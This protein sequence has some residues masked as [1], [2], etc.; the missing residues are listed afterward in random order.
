MLSFLTANLPTKMLDFRGFDYARLES[1]LALR[2][3][4]ACG[5][6]VARP[7]LKMP[8]GCR[9]ALRFACLGDLRANCTHLV[10]LLAVAR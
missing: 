7:C 1:G 9:H 3:R 4:T 8:P 5:F 6:A 10:S 2:S